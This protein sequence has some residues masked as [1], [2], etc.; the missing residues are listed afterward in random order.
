[1]VYIPRVQPSNKV[2]L[3]LAP[4]FTYFGR[5]IGFVLDLIGIWHTYGSKVMQQC[6][7][8]RYDSFKES[9]Q[10]R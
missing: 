4:Y 7:C 10:S 5:A 3:N 9:N 6:G 2:V 1:M 8:S